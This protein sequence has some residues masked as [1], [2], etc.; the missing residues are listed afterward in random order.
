[1]TPARAWWAPPR[2]KEHGMGLMI[3]VT[4]RQWAMALDHL[5]TTG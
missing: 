3:T 2:P 5:T 4:R 1:M